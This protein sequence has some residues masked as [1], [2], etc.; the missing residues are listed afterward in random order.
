MPTAII[1]VFALA[2]LTFLTALADAGPNKHG[3]WQAH[4]A[5][6]NAVRRLFPEMYAD[7][8]AKVTQMAAGGLVTSPSAADLPSTAA[9]DVE[10]YLQSANADAGTRVRL[11]RLAFDATMSGF[12]GRQILY[13]RFFGGDPVRTANRHVKGYEKKPLIDKVRKFLDRAAADNEA[14]EQHAAE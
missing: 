7:I 3:V 8:C 12:A 9:P 2:A 5:P 13:E 14:M 4:T 6:F 10:R 1:A 11:M